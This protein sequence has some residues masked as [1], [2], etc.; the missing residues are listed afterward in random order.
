[1]SVLEPAQPVR[2]FIA[3]AQPIVLEGLRAVLGAEPRFEIVGEARDAEETL[4]RCRRV[5]PD[6]LVL[7]PLLPGARNLELARSVLAGCDGCRILIFAAHADR[8]PLADIL[9]AGASGYVLK[10][11][12]VEHI[13][14]ALEVISAGGVYI[15]AGPAG[16]AAR[17]QDEAAGVVGLSAREL[18]VMKLTAL[19]HS[20]KSVAAELDIG[21]KSAETYKA[22]AMEKLGFRTRV[23]VV[24]FAA[25]NGWLSA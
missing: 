15:G 3:D 17:A 10:R 2:V 20:N 16:A 25:A 6:V 18:D 7:D 21:V 23:E 9:R 4:E 11:S 22:R 24:R 12:G 14:E 1:M 8:L 19:G 5:R 13:I